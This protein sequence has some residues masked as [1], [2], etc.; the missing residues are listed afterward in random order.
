[1]G[2]AL[3]ADLPWGQ[4]IQLGTGK[5]TSV[6]SLICLLREVVGESPFPAVAYAPPRPGE[7][8]RNFVD[9]DKARRFL[10]F[11]PQTCLAEGLQEAWK[12]FLGQK[13]LSL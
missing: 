2:A 8:K 11:H 4:A 9:I 3:E 10:N 13:D 12:W 6:N 7:V 1:M 5:E